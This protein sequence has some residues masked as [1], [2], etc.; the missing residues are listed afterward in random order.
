M[1]SRDVR[2]PKG[3]NAALGMTS[4]ALR[5]R[6]RQS[7]AQASS[8]ALQD[9]FVRVLL[10][11]GFAKTTVREVAAVAGVGVGTFY[12]Y[13]GNMRTLAALCISQSVKSVADR[14]RQAYEDRRGQPLTAIVDAMLDCQVQAV[15]NDAP[16][17][18]A[19]FFLERQISSPESFRRHYSAWVGMWSDAL[20][21]A[22]N[23]PP[24]E[25]IPGAA[26]TM[27]VISYGWIS[28]CLLTVGASMD[29]RLLRE[30]LE[31][32]VHGYLSRA[33]FAPSTPRG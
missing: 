12:E 28:Q 17:W 26:R 4:H 20:A 31:R 3:A 15:M 23:P 5:R 10:E 18:S 25:R 33:E 22:G 27:H 30:E 11:R 32:A 16:V 1:S 21:A 29:A 7:R 19:L 6:P 2:I 9:A 24:P 8:Q 14:V 13:F